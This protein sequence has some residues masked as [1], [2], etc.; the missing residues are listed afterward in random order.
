VATNG[1]RKDGATDGVDGLAAFVERHGD[2]AAEVLWWGALSL[3]ERAAHEAREGNWGRWRHYPRGELRRLRRD[4]AEALELARL[5]VAFQDEENARMRD[6]GVDLRR[7]AAEVAAAHRR[8]GTR[9]AERVRLLRARCRK[10]GREPTPEELHPWLF[11][12][13]AAEPG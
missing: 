10:E 9:E 11:N 8:D 1:N 2:H 4:L 6:L 7:E 5:A 12:G 13:G 3:L